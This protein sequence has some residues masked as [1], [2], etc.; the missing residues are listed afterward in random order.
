MGDDSPRDGGQLEGAR[1]TLVALGVVVLEGH[2]RSNR[3]RKEAK[4]QSSWYLI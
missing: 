4:V 3:H 2:L 1:E